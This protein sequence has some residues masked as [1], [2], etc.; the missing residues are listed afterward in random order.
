MIGSLLVMVLVG[1]GDAAPIPHDGDPR[2]L[3]D[4]RWLARPLGGEPFLVDTF[5]EPGKPKKHGKTFVLAEIEGPGVVEHLTLYTRAKLWIEVDGRTIWE[6]HPAKDWPA[7]Y[8][9]PKPK[10]RGTPPFAF[11]MV[12][13]AWGPSHMA[14]PIPFDKRLVLRA[15]AGN[16][17]LWLA[18][19]Q[20][21]Y[22]GRR[23]VTDASYRKAADEVFANWNG[24]IHDPYPIPG[25]RKMRLE[26]YVEASSRARLLEL[27]GS[28]EVTGLKLRID[29]PAFSVLRQLVIEITADGLSEPT[30][31]MPILDFVGVTH[32]WPHAWF[33]MAGDRVAG[34][35]NGVYR[36]NKQNRHQDQFILYFKLP[37]PFQRGLR[38]DVRNRSAELPV[39]V[40][41]TARVCPLSS[42]EAGRALRLCGTS[43]RLDLPRNKG[44]VDLLTLPGD[45]HL[46]GFSFFT[47]GH[48][49][50]G[51][52]RSRLRIELLDA[53]RR[54]LASG[55][56][57]NPYGKWGNNQ[58]FRAL[59]WNHNSNGPKGLMGAGRHFWLDPRPIGTG[60]TLRY[61]GGGPNGPGRAEV[62]VIW[63][64]KPGSDG[65]VAYAAP[66]QP[67]DVEPLPAVYRGWRRPGKPGGWG[68]E[69]ESLA[70][71]ATATDG[72]VRA[73]TVGAW[74][75]FASGAAYLAWNA[76]R[77][78]ASMD[79]LVP[80]PP[81][82][83]V[84][85]WYHRLQFP[86]GASFELELVRLNEP[87]TR[88]EYSKDDAGFRSRVLG[89]STGR[90][91][92][93]SFG[94]V[95]W[96]QP[97]VDML[98][99]MRNPS[100]GHLARLRFRC[101]TKQGRAYLLVLDQLGMNPCPATPKGWQEFEAAPVI[102]A[103]LDV[104]AD[105]MKYGR[106][107]F[108]GWGGREMQARLPGA[109]TIML[110]RLTAAPAGKSVQIRG[111]LEE[112]R[113]TLRVQG[114][115]TGEVTLELK[116]GDKP[117][118]EPSLWTIPLSGPLAAPVTARLSV[119]CHSRTGRLLLD[120][121]RL[122]N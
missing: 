16:V 60:A 39:I 55:P 3:L 27:P 47:T 6:G 95:P 44:Q 40:R 77:P 82:L 11:P 21:R 110:V 103:G 94:V 50:F 115:A 59:T 53:R 113:W 33:S 28:G 119:Q 32:P 67:S 101:I 92:I 56:G 7:I 80:T 5:S 48:Q 104:T 23:R 91:R 118:A 84:Q 68:A 42:K 96:R 62:G 90:A 24:P 116:K 43:R 100:P 22:I 13:T 112:G 120:G 86:S 15:D 97:G 79:L 29:P 107:D 46:V 20:L 1:A 34:L 83:Y 88:A 73:E 19:R 9:P 78:G 61:S 41:G 76:R 122:G 2:R 105:L 38:I 89:Q 99:I 111:R 109:A 81:T 106:R 114:E 121:W 25:S 31:R 93:N 87:V 45:G 4:L 36:V 66:A 8:V 37:I 14:L 74:D 108:H 57:L 64:Q 63:Y 18:G 52:W 49:T 65:R 70:A 58:M 10:D 85:P 12:Q 98:P 72:W 75:A 117:P 71:S 69:A 17:P 102:E 30:L 51:E 54:R 35:T 26:A